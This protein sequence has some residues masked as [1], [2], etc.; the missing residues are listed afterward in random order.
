MKST[1]D[2]SEIPVR[3]ADAGGDTGCPS[4]RREAYLLSSEFAF[5]TDRA[6]FEYEYA[7]AG[8]ML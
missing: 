7:T 5:E 8:S 6:S 3:D 1:A 4:D 2:Q